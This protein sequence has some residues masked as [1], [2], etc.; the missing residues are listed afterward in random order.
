MKPAT[1]K[2]QTGACAK[3]ELAK[4]ARHPGQ[5]IDRKAEGEKSKTQK[6]GDA[7]GAKDAKEAEDEDKQEKQDRVDRAVKGEREVERKGK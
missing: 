7:R 5:T 4:I 3:E 2:L 1:V 6:V